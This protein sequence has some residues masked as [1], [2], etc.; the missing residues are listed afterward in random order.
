MVL[1]TSVLIAILL[2]EPEADRFLDFIGRTDF[3]FLSTVSFIEAHIVAVGR[4]KEPGGSRLR[5]LV[6]ALETTLVP[7]DEEQAFLAQD[8]FDRYGKGRHPAQLNFGD[9]ISYAAARSLNEPLLF[10]GDDFSKTD[11]Q[12]ALS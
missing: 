5:R 4:L 11:I 8:A 7:V 1:D 2:N 6:D 10:K 3:C 12:P 9:C